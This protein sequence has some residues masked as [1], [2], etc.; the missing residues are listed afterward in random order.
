MLTKIG[1]GVRAK[2]GACWGG[3]GLG[4]QYD[5]DFIAKNRIALHEFK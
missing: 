4:V 5:W 2:A 3:P 1:R